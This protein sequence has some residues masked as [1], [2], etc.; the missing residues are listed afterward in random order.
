MG[1]ETNERRHTGGFGWAL[2]MVLGLSFGVAAWWMTGQ[3][4]MLLVIFVATGT[5]LGFALERSLHP[6]PLTPRQRR[7]LLVLLTFGVVA[8]VLAFLA[9]AGL[10]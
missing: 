7:I 10:R 3:I 6:A 4:T 8:G 1:T 9:G 2:G 5:A